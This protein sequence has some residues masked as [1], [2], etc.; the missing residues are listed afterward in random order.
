MN[1]EEIKSSLENMLNENYADFTKAIIAIEKDISNP[2]VLEQIYQAYLNDD[3]ISGL[4]HSN[5]DAIIDTL[6]SDK[7]QLST[8]SVELVGNVIKD[9]E[10]KVFSG[11]DGKEFKVANFTIARND[12]NGDSHFTNVTAYN[13]RAEFADKLKKGDF[14]KLTGNMK[15]EEHN[16]NIYKK[17]IV[18][19][20]HILKTR[21][22]YMEEKSAKP[23]TLGVLQD[24]SKQ[25]KSVQPKANR[26][27]GM[28]L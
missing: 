14:V 6:G 7:S 4:L 3:S 1:F 2:D 15:F 19:N 16:G 27:K 17:L 11:E 10:V 25:T 8:D 9:V 20:I 22:K 21:E 23:S 28:E 5:I 13:E 18:K 24:Y 12:E 26:E